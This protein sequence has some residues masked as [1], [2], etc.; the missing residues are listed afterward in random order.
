MQNFSDLSGFTAIQQK[1]L[2]EV[3][4]EG[5][6]F[7]THERIV[8]VDG[9]VI[10]PAHYMIKKIP[11]QFGDVKG[12][13]DI[14]SCEELESLIGSPRRTGNYY[15]CGLCTNLE[16]LEGAPNHVGARF[17]CAGCTKLKSLKFLPKYV[18]GEIRCKNCD[19]LSPEESTI[20]KDIDMLRM[21]LN[22]DMSAVVFLPQIQR[23]SFV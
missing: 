1:F 15:T 19:S 2:R 7:V 10:V 17:S 21:W 20:A 11:V 8:N 13:F 5:T 18:V 6:I 3:C 16:S 12:F 23:K 9:D 14:S 22:S 4:H